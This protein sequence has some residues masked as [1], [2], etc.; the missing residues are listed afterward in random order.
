MSDAQLES[1]KPADRN[2]SVSFFEHSNLL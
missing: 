1:G 2:S